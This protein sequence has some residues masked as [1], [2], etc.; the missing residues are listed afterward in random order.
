MTCGAGLYGA[1]T[2]LGRTW[3]SSSLSS[4]S[5]AARSA[6]LHLK[7][8]RG[9]I[10]GIEVKALDSPGGRTSEA[11]R[12]DARHARRTLPAGWCAAAHGYCGGASGRPAVVG[13]GGCAVEGGASGTVS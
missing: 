10:V 1:A 13:A 12:G 7:D 2:A 8:R 9:R 6:T 11:S 3:T 4:S 5:V